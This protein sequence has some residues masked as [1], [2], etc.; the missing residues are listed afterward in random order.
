MF[1]INNVRCRRQE[2]GERRKVIGGR[3]KVIGGRRKVMGVIVSS[4]QF[5]VF[6]LL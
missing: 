1:K 5:Q 4:F 3:R 6:S 2:T